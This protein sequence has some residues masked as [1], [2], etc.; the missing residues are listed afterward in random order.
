[1]DV[2]NVTSIISTTTTRLTE[3]ERRTNVLLTELDRPLIPHMA[4]NTSAIGIPKSPAILRAD[5]DALSDDSDAGSPEKFFGRQP[6]NI[7]KFDGS[8]FAD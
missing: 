3:S 8:A 7:R 5:I 4:S 2:P 1:M 6:P